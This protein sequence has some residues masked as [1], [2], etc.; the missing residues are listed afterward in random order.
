MANL[1]V[2]IKIVLD[3]D[4]EEADPGIFNDYTAVADMVE[5]TAASSGFIKG[6]WQLKAGAVQ[7]LYVDQIELKNVV[8]DSKHC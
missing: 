8:Y 2:T 5:Q 7:E 3:L 4:D 1:E 6:L